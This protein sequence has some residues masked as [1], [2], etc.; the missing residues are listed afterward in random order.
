[1]SKLF[2]LVDKLLYFLDSL[3]YTFAIFLNR[4]QVHNYSASDNTQISLFQ[5]ISLG[6]LLLL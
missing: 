5:G 2:K 1:M 3:G 6:K 4:T